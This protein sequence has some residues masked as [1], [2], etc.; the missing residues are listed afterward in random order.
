MTLSVFYMALLKEI[1]SGTF[2]CVGCR[3]AQP[4]FRDGQQEPCTYMIPPTPNLPALPK[5]F[6]APPGWFGAGVGTDNEVPEASVPSLLPW[7]TPR[8]QAP[9]KNKYLLENSDFF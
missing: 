3:G 7:G 4:H 6:C 5:G 1:L 9:G 2:R 8:A